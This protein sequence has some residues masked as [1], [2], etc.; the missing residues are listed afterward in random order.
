[1]IRKTIPFIALLL[2]TFY[3]RAQTV[4]GSIVQPESGKATASKGTVGTGIVDVDPYTGTGSVNVPIFSYSVDELT[5]PIG[6]TYSARGIRVDE[7]SSPVGLGWELSYGGSIT[8][9][10]KGIEDE[11]TLPAIFTGSTTDHFEGFLVPGANHGV[12]YHG[13]D[14]DDEE[15]DIFRLDLGGRSFEFSF[16]S[17][18]TYKTVPQSE[19]SIQVQTKDWNPTTKAYYNIRTGVQNN[20]SLGPDTN[21]IGFIVTDEKGNKF[22]FDRGDYRTKEYSLPAANFSNNTGVYYPTDKWN[23]VKVI[24]YAGKEVKFEF[25]TR[26]VEFVENITETLYPRE[27]T[28][29][30][31]PVGDP[32]VTFDPFEI[33]KQYFKGI[34][35]FPS[36]IIYPNDI[37][38]LFSVDTGFNARCDCRRNYLLNSITIESFDQF[39]YRNTLTFRLS[40]KYFSTKDPALG[41]AVTEKPKSSTC[42]LTVG[43]INTPAGQNT[44]TVKE[45]YMERGLRLKLTGIERIGTDELSSEPYYVFDYIDTALPYRF[46]GAKDFYGYYNGATVYPHIRP[47]LMAGV[48]S[49]PANA[50]DTFWTSIPYHQD[51]RTAYDNTTANQTPLYWGTSRNSNRLYAQAWSLNRITNGCGG[52]D[53]IVYIDY[54]LTNPDSAYGSVVVYDDP[55]GGYPSFLSM[56]YD[57]DTLTEY[58]EVNDGLVVGEIISKDWFARDNVTKTTYTYSGGQRFNQGGFT[59]Y[60]DSYNGE[61]AF[62]NFNLNADLYYNGVNHGFSEVTVSTLGYNNIQLSKTKVYFTNLTY[63]DGG[64]ETLSCLTKPTKKGYYSYPSTLKQWR[65]GIPLKTEDYDENNFLTSKTETTYSELADRMLV[66]NEKVTSNINDRS[67]SVVKSMITNTKFRY[68]QYDNITMTAKTNSE[69]DSIKI[70]TKY[71]YDYSGMFPGSAVAQMATEQRQ[72]LISSETWKKKP[73]VPNDSS[74][75]GI[76]MKAPKYRA[77]GVLSFPALFQ[78]TLKAPLTPINVFPTSGHSTY[79][80]RY[81]VA[82]NGSNYTSFGTNLLKWKEATKYDSKGDE[83]E[84][85]LNAQDEYVSK[86]FDVNTGGLLAYASNARHDDIAFS[87]FESKYVYTSP[88]YNKGNFEFSPDNVVEIGSAITGRYAYDLKDYYGVTTKPLGS[89]KYIL[90]YWTKYSQYI[91]DVHLQRGGSN[92]ILTSTLRNTVG[93]W[94][95]YSVEHSAQS[96]DVL[97]IE[98]HP[99][100]ITGPPFTTYVD[101]VRLHP[102]DAAM[103]S[104]CY[105]PLFGKT[106]ETD[107]S[108]HILYYEHD[109]FGNTIYEKDMRGNVLSKIE[110]EC[111][112]LDGYES[113]PDY[114]YNDP[115]FPDPVNP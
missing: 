11:V 32:I 37:N 74:F 25:Y 53:S 34:K 89:K 33:K 60:P 45:R 68:D 39:E 3:G 115:H 28:Y 52:V 101:E 9:E 75:L 79:V 110:Q 97:S 43:S 4:N 92:T 6:L 1:M 48:G 102:A 80:P 8:R 69:G 19:L 42:A 61:K 73:G 14:D 106:S 38:V 108:N 105:T 20:V 51:P 21:I 98:Q 86:I 40:H 2:G 12:Y 56:G 77:T 112:S 85:Q 87:S 72:F 66:S 71:N 104:Y 90:T 64:G 5:F 93:E 96:G 111:M 13:D 58:M 78:S 84:I 83:I 107:A 94:Q 54:T 29:Y 24:S 50:K 27:Q 67:A 49:I 82:Y 31:P 44:D 100:G 59:W 16:Q 41:I 15:P 76:T 95:L 10:V 7:M 46:Y 23:L 65:M 63:Q 91:P 70:W 36:K 57:Q 103:T 99:V 30:S 17:N 47:N 18:G 35:T 26:Y 81:A 55:M 22:Y 113:L 88:D 62:T 114:D 109:M